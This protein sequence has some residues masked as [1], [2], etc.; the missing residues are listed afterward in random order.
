MMRTKRKLGI[1]TLAG[2]LLLGGIYGADV[3]LG[4]A[5]A[6]SATT[7]TYGQNTKQ[8]IG[9]AKA[10]EQA[11]AVV[12]GT[13]ESVEL[14]RSRS[15]VLYYEVE[16]EKSTGQEVDVLIDAYTGKS[17]GV[18]VD[19]DADDD[20]DYKAAAGTNAA[21]TASAAAAKIS[22]QEAANIALKAAGGSEVLE[23]D[24]DR[25]DGRLE[26]EVEVRISGG[27]SDVEIDAHTGKVLSV[28]KDYDDDDHAW[29]SDDGDDD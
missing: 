4:Q 14:E 17:L 7:A 25:D 27:T 29:D 18:R 15:G 16:I 23:L 28:N 6:A 21:S 11:L 8:R 22:R 13:V 2:A 12:Q 3:L 26:Y 19:D 24:L 10:S 5:D 20:D 1:S 9:A